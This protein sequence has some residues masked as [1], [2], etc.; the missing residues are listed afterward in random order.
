MSP[1]LPVEAIRQELESALSKGSLVLTS[2]TGSGKSTQVPRWLQAQGP[3]LVV[4]PRRVACRSLARYVAE[5][6]GTKLGARVGFLHR[7]AQALGPKTK[8]LFVTPGMALNLLEGTFLGPDGILVLDEFHERGLETDLLYALARA[9]GQTMVVMSATLDA[10]RLAKNL[11]A[12]WIRAEGRSFEVQELHAPES[13][14][15][16]R[17]EGLESRVH[18]ALKL[19]LSESPK[20]N[21]LV[22]LPGK[23]SIEAC[24]KACQDLAFEFELLPFHGGLSHA[25]Q[26][27]AFSPSPRR[28]I[29]FATNVAETSLTL[30]EV[31]LVVDSGLEKRMVYRQ[32]RA[33]LEVQAIAKDSAAQRAGR[34]GRV[35]AGLALKLWSPGAVLEARTAPELHRLPL[36]RL[37]LEVSARGSSPEA[38]PWLE[39]PRP[40]AIADAEANLVRLGLLGPDR[41]LS[42]RGKEAARLP[43]DPFLAALALHPK[44]R[45]DPQARRWIAWLEAGHRPA[46]KDREEALEPYRGDLEAL[47]QTQGGPPEGQT[48]AFEE[49]RSLLRI[50]RAELP[51]DGSRSSQDP[52]EPEDRGELEA[53]R[54]RFLEAALEVDPDRVLVRRADKD[55]FTHGSGE[56]RLS[57]ESRIRESCQA[58]FAWSFFTKEGSRGPETWVSLASPLDFSTLA[59]RGVGVRRLKS[60][61]LAEDRQGLFAQWE[62]RYAGRVLALEEGPPP[63]ELLIPSLTQLLLRGKLFPSVRRQLGTRLRWQNLHRSLDGYEVELATESDWL[64]SQLGSLGV[65]SFEDLALL[66]VEDLLPPPLE[67]RRQ[68][69]LEELFPAK[70]P[71]PQGVFAL[72][73]DGVTKT[74]RLRAPKGVKQA[75]K[76]RDLP[77]WEG[78]RVEVWIQN[79]PQTLRR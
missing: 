12:T 23:R 1:R 33:S 39:A 13:P 59:Q 64:S 46:K 20:G 56:F 15:L 58:L 69:E 71:T 22:F 75:P 31:S 74:I 48:R 57:R 67:A 21:A 9:K 28:R 8:I 32:G 60:I 10:E 24:R 42:P 53:A 30:P 25:E 3:V 54:L 17:L 72:E 50:L 77:R 35:R 6:E 34:A 11:S 45:G 51:Q 19:G 68:A 5:L 47:I 70:L 78:F 37:V 7:G 18:R 73:V 26:D 76:S 36:E 65:E 4:E 63:P 62:R 61:E 52:E 2:E 38:L 79:R 55:R 41:R 27:R 44:L 49:S 29:F 40:Y 14:L 43:L 66:E 16:P